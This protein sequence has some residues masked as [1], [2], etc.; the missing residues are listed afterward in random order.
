MATET[1][2]NKQTLFFVVLGQKYTTH[3]V[4]AKSETMRAGPLFRYF[5]V[6]MELLLKVHS[7]T[8]YLLYKRQLSVKNLT[9]YSCAD[10]V[11]PWWY[12]QR[13]CLNKWRHLNEKYVGM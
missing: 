3:K 2:S 7:S 10:F 4:W 1:E 9:N 13:V 8:F 6:Y 12:K 5:V 11:S